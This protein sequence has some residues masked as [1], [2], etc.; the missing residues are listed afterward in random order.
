MTSDD[1][2]ICIFAGQIQQILMGHHEH[3]RARVAFSVHTDAV[4]EGYG[5]H[6]VVRFTN[7]FT[8]VGQ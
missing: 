1:V 6:H 7:I 2:M 4:S 5:P 8:N 3:M